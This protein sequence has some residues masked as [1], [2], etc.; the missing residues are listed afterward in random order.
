MSIFH[1][2]L[3]DREGVRKKNIFFVKLAKRLYSSKEAYFFG[4]NYTIA[5]N[6]LTDY[7]ACRKLSEI[8]F[9]IHK[10]CIIIFSSF[11]AYIEGFVAMC[12]G[13]RKTCGFIM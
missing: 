9:Q 8:D 10:R 2:E 5:N 4:V 13:L 7:K 3:N 12:I 1:H 6:F 11:G